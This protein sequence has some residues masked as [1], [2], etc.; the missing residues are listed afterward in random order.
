MP[1]VDP[2]ASAGIDLDS[3]FIQ[4]IMTSSPNAVGVKLTCGSVGKVTRLTQHPRSTAQGGDFLVLNGFADHLLPS[5]S[6][7]ASGAIT[8]FANLC[9]VRSSLSQTYSSK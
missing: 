1:I 5:A 4:Q 8:G 3:D 9:P 7:R 2:G 6:V